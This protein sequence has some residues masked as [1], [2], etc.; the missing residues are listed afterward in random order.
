[1]GVDYAAGYYSTGGG[2][3][4]HSACTVAS[5]LA[6][7]DCHNCVIRTGELS[8]FRQVNAK[9]IFARIVVCLYISCLRLSVHASNYS[10]RLVP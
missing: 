1:M 3:A 10:R 6:A 5:V 4:A 8:L 9:M 2:S 7:N